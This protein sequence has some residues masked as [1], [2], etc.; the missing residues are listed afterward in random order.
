MS[1]AMCWRL[2][3]RAG[4]IHMRSGV[5]CRTAEPPGYACYRYWQPSPSCA[6]RSACHHCPPPSPNT[7]TTTLHSIPFR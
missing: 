1:C 5:V 7:T 3:M 6:C 4:S 2:A